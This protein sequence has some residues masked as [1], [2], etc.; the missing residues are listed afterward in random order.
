MMIYRPNTAW[1]DVNAG[2]RWSENQN[3][4]ED[5]GPANPSKYMDLDSF[6]AKPLEHPTFEFID[7]YWVVAGGTIDEVGD[8]F[9]AFDEKN[10]VISQRVADII[11]QFEPDLH[12]IVQIPRMWSFGSQQRIERPCYF[13]NVH[14][15]ARTVDM[16]RSQIAQI[17]QKNTG[18]EVIRLRALTKEACV[19]LA[20]AAHGRHLWRDDITLATFMSEELVRA[21]KSAEVR[22]FNFK[23][24]TVITH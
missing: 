3:P 6:T 22:G 24:C 5:T 8:I 12:D 13:I 19:V 11:R 23:E 18:R 20:D 4:K 9:Q 16:G 7:R 1:E 2:L 14:A 15:T 17:T 10:A 21:L